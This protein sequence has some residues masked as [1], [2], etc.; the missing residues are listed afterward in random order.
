MS[1][2]SKIVYVE[3]NAADAE[4]FEENVARAGFSADVIT[5]GD[6]AACMS[7]LRAAASDE[8]ALPDLLVFDLKMPGQSGIHILQS[9][10]EIPEFDATPVV[11]FSGSMGPQEKAECLRNGASLCLEKPRA[12]AEWDQIMSSL[13]SFLAVR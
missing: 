1:F 4:L 5:L 7:Y 8:Q 6:M 13:S 2:H 12:A 9:V 10:R 3:D 11:I